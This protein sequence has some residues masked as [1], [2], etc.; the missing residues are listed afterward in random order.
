[1]NVDLRDL[2][3]LA[4]VITDV[5]LSLSLSLSLPFSHEDDRAT[6]ERTCSMGTASTVIHTGVLALEP[7]TTLA[8]FLSLSRSL[9]LSVSLV[10]QHVSDAHAS[11]AC[12][13]CALS[14]FALYL[15]FSLP[16][17]VF[18]FLS[19]FIPFSPLFQNIGLSP[20]SRYTLCTDLGSRISEACFP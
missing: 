19:H 3:I 18:L 2:R 16:L 17:A 4:F 10:C 15:V 1:V 14:V 12:A 5:S 9:S 13:S 8:L 20:V 11:Y 6:E 7:H